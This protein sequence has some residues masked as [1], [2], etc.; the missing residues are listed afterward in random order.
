[1]KIDCLNKKIK[2]ER[3]QIEQSWKEIA[4]WE[5]SGAVEL[6]NSFVEIANALSD[7]EELGCDIGNAYKALSAMIHS[8]QKPVNRQL[9]EQWL[10]E[11]KF[12]Y[13][14]YATK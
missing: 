3:E 12:V 8:I 5:N 9:I 4:E 13:K 11:G 1:M 6:W 7:F 2:S 10:N 14:K